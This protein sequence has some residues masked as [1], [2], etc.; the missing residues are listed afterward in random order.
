MIHSRKNEL[1]LTDNDI[2]AHFDE[3]KFKGNNNQS[4]L[5]FNIINML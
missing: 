3:I 2:G 4:L 1:K 5:L